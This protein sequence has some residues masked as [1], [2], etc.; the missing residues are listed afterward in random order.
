M[1]LAVDPAIGQ[2]SCAALMYVRALLCAVALDVLIYCCIA[3]GRR[4]LDHLRAWYR[5]SV[6]FFCVRK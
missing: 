2:H 4:A 1:A 6:F 3:L 5:L